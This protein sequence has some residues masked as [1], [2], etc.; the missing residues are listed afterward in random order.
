MLVIKRNHNKN[1]L[2]NNNNYQRLTK[3]KVS[4]QGINHELISSASKGS[5]LTNK[6]SKTGD[7]SVKPSKIRK[8]ISL[9]L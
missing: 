9:N 7:F 3:G 2:K 6:L 5:N 4:G 1:I 8:Y